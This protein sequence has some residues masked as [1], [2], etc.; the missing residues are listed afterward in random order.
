MKKGISLCVMCFWLGQTLS[1]AQVEGTLLRER[2]ADGNRS[3][4]SLPDSAQWW[5]AANNPA[6][7]DAVEAGRWRI[8]NSGSGSFF[9][10]ARFSEPQGRSLMPGEVLVWRFELSFGQSSSISRALRIAVLDSRGEG[11][12]SDLSWT[13][14]AAFTSY[15]GYGLLSALSNS[16]R[17]DGLLLVRRAGGSDALFTIHAGGFDQTVSSSRG[18]GLTPGS[19]TQ[20]ELRLERS[21]DGGSLRIVGKVGAFKIESVQSLDVALLTFD[22]IAVFSDGNNG[23]ITLSQID[24]WAGNSADEPVPFR[25]GNFVDQYFDVPTASVV[26]PFADADGDGRNNLLEYALAGHPHQAGSALVP[27]LSVFPGV[28]GQARVPKLLYP[29]PPEDIEARVLVSDSLAPGSWSAGQPSSPLLDTETNTITQSFPADSGKDKFFM[30]IQYQMKD[31]LVAPS[32]GGYRG[33][34]FTLGQFSEFGDKYSGGLGTYTSHHTPM[35]I[36]APE[37]NRTF[38]TF[39]GTPSADRRY[40]L[41]MAGA[42]DHET[43][44]VLRPVVVRDKGIS[45]VNDPHDNGS[46]AID[47]AGHLWVFVSGRNVSRLGAIYRSRLPYSIND[48]ELVYEGNFTYPQ[49]WWVEGEG[50]FYLHTRYAN[51]STR[52]LYLHRGQNG[53]DWADPQLLV[54]FG[55]HYQVSDHKN[56]RVITAFNRHPD[57]N[58]DAR[59]D[60]YF[61]ETSDFG[62]NWTSVDGTRL[63]MPLMSPENPALVRDYAA[64]GTLVYLMDTTFDAQGRPILLYVTSKDHRPGPGGDPR[65]WT[66]AH[67][68]GGQWQFHK[69]APAG[70]NYDTGSIQ[71]DPDG[72]WRFTGPTGTG[73]QVHGTGGEIEMW[74]SHDEGHSWVRVRTLTQ[75]SE[76]NHGYARRPRHAHPEFHTYWAD[77]N[78]DALSPSHLYFTNRAGDTVWRLPYT[79][80]GERAQ[81]EKVFPK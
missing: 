73:P 15:A 45:G 37:V 36:Y 6:S 31:P 1:T 39:G 5:L 80:Q 70:H 7:T 30:K 52:N 61:M 58:A 22:T 65:F 34:W 67:W 18:G 44:E 55:G 13:Q 29:S 54:A 62:K 14:D 8:D 81:P 60:L 35:A 10:L 12:R 68:D 69:I 59:T 26:N 43:D 57:S 4:S 27:Q 3:G 32:V 66:I 51:G 79:M 64:E 9:A 25:W 28:D 40:L 42:Y 74:T 33:I 17:S 19:R 56:G 41:I 72:T 48:W 63:E 78:P 71:L 46:I 50:F 77:G 16:E 75:N 76:F 38:F 23:P 24:V 21:A 53:R 20:V 49:P 11:M 47:G 2:F